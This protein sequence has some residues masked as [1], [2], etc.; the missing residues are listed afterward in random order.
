[1]YAPAVPQN[2]ACR[3]AAELLR[4][5][6]RVVVL[7]G[8]GISTE[9]GIPDFRSPGGLWSRYDP[10]KLTFDRFRANLETRKLYW[11]IA[12]QSY[13]LM[14]DALPNAAHEAFVA[15]ERAGRL[16]A[17]VTQNVD[18]LHQKAGSS[19]ERTIEIHGTAMGVVCIDCGQRADR[20]AI[21][22]QV[23][24]GDEDPVC[25]ACGGPL[26][27]ATIS[28]GQAMPERETAAAFRAAAECDLMIV[29]GS[30]LVVYPAAGLPEEAVRAGARL[31]IVNREP[32]GHDALAS[33]VVHGSAGESMRRIVA[34]A[35]IAPAGAVYDA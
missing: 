8:A 9:S 33:V 29:A 23:L 30:S 35:G 15:I 14:R 3:Q 32:T 27:P 7:T 1:M 19:P 28:F 26:K 4:A 12:C 34:E 24:A 16:L 13:P 17:L 11:Q 5:A 21:H 25:D 18:G 31:V 22:R 20:E 10:S 2:D 6:R